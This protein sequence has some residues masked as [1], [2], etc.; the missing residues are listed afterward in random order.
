MVNA[1]IELGYNGNVERTVLASL[2]I[3]IIDSIAINPLLVLSR[4]KIGS[5][6]IFKNLF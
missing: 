3:N 4:A 1:P 2:L 5:Y 6:S